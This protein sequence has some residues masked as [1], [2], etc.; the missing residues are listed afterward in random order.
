MVNLNSAA[1]AF[2]AILT[3]V[4]NGTVNR[5]ARFVVT[6]L[7][8]DPNLVWIFAEG[9]TPANRLDVPIV[10]GLKRGQPVR[11][12]L[13]TSFQ[14]CLNDSREHPSVQSSVFALVIGEKSKRPA[15][16]V[17]YE[18][19]RGNEPDDAT[20]GVHRRSAAHVQIHGSSEELAYIQ[21][22]QGG[23]PLRGLEKFH[24]PV[25]GRRFRPSLEDFIE[26]LWAE[27]LIGPLH[28]GWQEVLAKHRSHWL[29]LQLQAAV[30]SDP[31]T[32]IAQLEA[33]G[34]MLSPS[35]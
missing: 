19:G 27:R 29:D 3:A 17:E 10:A 16:R 13:G 25:G 9:S 35:T 12:W 8:D 31:I 11:L 21:G 14:V 23:E 15:V 28:N 33:M 20:A 2:A 34:Y 26:F 4:V 22:L 24:I 32:A 18:R 1:A 30:R 7:K 6:P 5:D